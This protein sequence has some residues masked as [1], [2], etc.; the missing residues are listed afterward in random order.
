MHRWGC[1]ARR[2]KKE[3]CECV[4]KDTGYGYGEK[5]ECECVKK[6]TGYGYGNRD[7]GYGY[8]KMED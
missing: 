1:R 3:E 5:D 6:D 2:W 7:A 4:K 8:G